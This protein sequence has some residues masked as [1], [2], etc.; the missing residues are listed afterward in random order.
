[1][2]WGGYNDGSSNTTPEAQARIAAQLPV[3]D[4]EAAFAKKYGTDPTLGADT[5]ANHAAA[6]EWRKKRDSYSTEQKI[7]LM[8][9]YYGKDTPDATDTML[10]NAATG[11]L[12]KARGGSTANSF[13]G[14][15][16]DPTSPIG[17]GSILG[18]Y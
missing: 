8:Q 5:D 12:R 4:F 15:A 14:Q 17:R 9:E 7:A 6:L 3:A 13:I 1:M 2:G 10:R 16:F 11:K 18:D